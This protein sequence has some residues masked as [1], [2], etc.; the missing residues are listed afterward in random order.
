MPQ[1]EIHSDTKL[2]RREGAAA[3]T[4][5]GYR[6]SPTTLATLGSRGGGPV[7]CKFGPRVLYKWGDLLAWAEKKTSKPVRSTSELGGRSSGAA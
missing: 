3:L 5:S 4:A 7:F 6:I 2:D 1:T